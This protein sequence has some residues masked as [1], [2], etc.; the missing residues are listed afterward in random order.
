VFAFGQRRVP[1]VLPVAPEQIE[2]NIAR[3]QPPQGGARP[4]AARHTQG[5]LGLALTLREA[6][7][8]LGMVGVTHGDRWPT[9]GDVQPILHSQVTA[10]ATLTKGT[11]LKYRT[12][13][14]HFQLVNC[15]T[16]R[17]AR[18][19]CPFANRSSFQLVNCGVNIPVI[20]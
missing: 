18:S 1:R 20:T 14:S 11:V 19:V 3:S 5:G 2:S 8:V 16:R 9:R 13:Y 6:R 10:T 15:A 17:R 7:S 4:K 12:A